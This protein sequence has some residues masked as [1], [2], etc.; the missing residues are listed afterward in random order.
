LIDTITVVFKEELQLLKIQARSFE[1]YIAPDLI[2]NVYIVVNDELDVLSLIDTAWW[3]VNAHKV[4]LIHRLAHGNFYFLDGWSSQQIHKL[5]AARDA[6]S[7]WSM[8]FDAKT[9]LVQ[10]LEWDKLFD[11]K[12][13]RF[14]SINTIDAFIKSRVY[15]ENLFNITLEKTIGPA[16]V[17]FMFHTATVKEM[18]EIIEETKG[19]K[20]GNFMALHM[21]DPD[22]VTEFILYSGFVKFK[23][24]DFGS[25]Y[26]ETQ[27]YGISNLDHFEL[28]R[29]SEIFSGMFK[30]FTIGMHRRVYP[31]LT[32]QQLGEWL[33]LLYSRNL[34]TGPQDLTDFC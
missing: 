22:R 6:E 17:P 3:G 5:C 29:F 15:V 18:C 33:S 12:K 8:C 16:G 19:E 34:I 23:Y 21:Y 30:A 13:A 4:K 11:G 27:V 24:G 2:R 20:F 25:L 10:P 26:S 9:W 14:N 28:D 1:L 7:E 32:E 31:K